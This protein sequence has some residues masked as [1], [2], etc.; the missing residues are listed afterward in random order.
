LRILVLHGPNLNLLGRRDPA[1]Y[2]DQTLAALD[3]T[4]VAWGA[5]RGHTVRCRQSNHEGELLDWLH[6]A[7]PGG[8]FDAVV[9]NPG[10]FSHTS[11]AIRDA[12]EALTGAGTPVVEVHLSQV[13]GREAF[14]AMLLTAGAASATLSGLG[15]HSYLLGLEA[16]VAL[17]SDNL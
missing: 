8:E 10:G 1:H 5:E 17:S 3:E 11:V 15:R 2:G 7:M 13:H 4:L 12:F 6:E 9:M 16:A 14:R